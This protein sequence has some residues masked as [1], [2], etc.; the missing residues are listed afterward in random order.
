[1]Q[2]RL[3]SWTW[4]LGHKPAP[5]LHPIRKLTALTGSGRQKQCA[6]RCH[7][8]GF[9]PE[10]LSL[11]SQ[12]CQSRT[13]SPK[14]H[15]SAPTGNLVVSVEACSV[16]YTDRKLARVLCR[17]RVWQHSCFSVHDSGWASEHVTLSP[18]KE[19]HLTLPHP[20][21]FMWVGAV[22][23]AQCICVPWVLQIITV[24]YSHKLEIDLSSS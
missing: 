12:M 21:Y 9:H 20:C 1:M 17:E 19:G 4:L 24:L 23:P 8:D 3:D 14:F 18:D 5:P 13:L 2:R 11:V 7:D 6:N 16:L 22:I 10:D 15:V